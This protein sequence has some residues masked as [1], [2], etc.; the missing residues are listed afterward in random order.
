MK[1]KE[2]KGGRQARKRREG[3]LRTN[4]VFYEHLARSS[5]Q[6]PI[7]VTSSYTHAAGVNIGS[8]TDRP[9]PTRGY[10]GTVGLPIRLLIRPRLGKRIIASWL[11]LDV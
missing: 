3:K 10:T 1:T 11:W 2:R 7:C 5:V 4:E 6:F 8:G 9:D